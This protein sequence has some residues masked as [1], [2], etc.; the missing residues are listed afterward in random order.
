MILVSRCLAGE[1][2]RYDGQCKGIPE[3]I[4][5]VEEGKAVTACPEVLGGLGVPRDPAE[6]QGE[7]VITCRG[8]D[9][10]ENYVRGA[11]TSLMIFRKHCCTMAVLKSRSPACGKGEIHDGR[12]D[13]G[14]TEGNGVFAEMLLKEGVRVMDEHEFIRTM[15]E[16]NADQ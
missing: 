12:F 1:P 2:C 10:T 7:R 3:I 5:L 6:R 4:K 14:M 8:K 16:N 9:V 13:G 11:E 15:E